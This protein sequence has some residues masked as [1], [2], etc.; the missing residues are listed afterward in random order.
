M[1]KISNFW[2]IVG[3]FLL[4]I[5]IPIII[6][7]VFNVCFN[8][9]NNI[10]NSACLIL[11]TM[12]VTLVLI[13]PFINYMVDDLAKINK[14]TLKKAYKNWLIGFGLMI[15]SNMIISLFTPNIASNEQY[16][17]ELLTKMPVYAVS[18]MVILAPISEE[19]VFRLSLKK[20]F[21]NKWVYA[22]VSGL[23]FGLFHLLSATSLIELLFIFPYG[24]L[25][26]FFAKSV[27]ETDSI[28]S[29]ILPHI[30]HNAFLIAL[31]FGQLIGA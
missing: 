3:T 23:L 10:I 30:T 7:N 6:S 20:S 13:L 11:G 26:F 27:W 1:S 9:S 5:Y 22:T 8:T 19:I 28:Y 24:V 21:N 29:S 31:M 2:K 4:Y 25:G 16:N 12:V 18:V 14:K 17:R 15:V